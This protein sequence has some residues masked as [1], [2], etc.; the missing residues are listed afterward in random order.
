MV[1]R[2]ERCVG[3]RF[4]A[5]PNPNGFMSTISTR[6]PVADVAAF[7]KCHPAQLSGP[8]GLP[9]MRCA[10]GSRLVALLLPICCMLLVQCRGKTSVIPFLGRGVVYS[11][12]FRQAQTV[13]VREL[14]ICCIH[15][16]RMAGAA[17]RDEHTQRAGVKAYVK[18]DTQGKRELSAGELD[19]AGASQVVT[20][21]DFRAQLIIMK[22]L[23]A[24][25]PQAVVVA[26]EDENEAQSTAEELDDL[27]S[28]F[29]EDID[30]DL[31]VPPDLAECSWDDL[32]VW[33]DPLDGTKE[34]A[35]GNLESATVLIGISFKQVP[36]A[37]VIHQP[38]RQ[39]ADGKSGSCTTWGIVGAGVRS[40]RLGKVCPGPAS[41]KHVAVLSE[42]KKD[43]DIVVSTLG[44]LPANTD[45]QRAGGCGNKLVQVIEQRADFMLQAPGSQRW[46]SA[47]GEAILRALGGGLCSL[48]GETYQYV[49]DGSHRNDGGL[50]AFRSSSLLEFAKPTVSN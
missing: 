5:F 23:K 6:S 19:N 44:R 36:V 32:T 22:C 42:S 29:S 15:A 24:N 28:C 37:G 14:L 3:F 11:A 49:R 8:S 30:V 12:Q 7:V 46:D 9:V 17:I 26:E 10:I 41:S 50:L 2:G 47:A 21:A 45:I 25:Y 35:R 34:F 16:A 1:Y 43:K 40:T 39:T 4:D 38:F 27:A 33:V 18:A 48:H 31:D 20:R 13:S